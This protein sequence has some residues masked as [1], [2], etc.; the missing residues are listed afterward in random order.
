MT[1]LHCTCSRG[2]GR[3]LA[4]SAA[5]ALLTPLALSAGLAWAQSLTIG[6]AS[7][8]TAADPHYH[9]VTPNDALAAHVFE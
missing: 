4:R 1:T 7:E 3:K 2:R 6:L 5:W 9:K 8:P